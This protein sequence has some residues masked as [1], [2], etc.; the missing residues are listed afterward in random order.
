MTNVAIA[1]LTLT[2]ALSGCSTNTSRL[3][4]PRYMPENWLAT[5][6]T[7]WQVKKLPEVNRNE[8]AN[9]IVK[10]NMERQG[11]YYSFFGNYKK[12]TQVEINSTI[13]RLNQAYLNLQYSPDAIYGSLTPNLDGISNTYSEREAGDAVM[14][15]ENI[16]M[17]RD[18]WDRLWMVNHPST[19]SPTPIVRD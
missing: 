18:D 9:L 12:S 4:N 2:V 5:S 6:P 13:E 11:Q 1:V 19:L 3:G 14:K 8:L 10:L 15:N 17:S 7:T 16:R